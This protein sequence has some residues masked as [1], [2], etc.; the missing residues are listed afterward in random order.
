M[1]RFRTVP[2]KKKMQFVFGENTVPKKRKEK[3]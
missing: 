3:K 1:R 2:E